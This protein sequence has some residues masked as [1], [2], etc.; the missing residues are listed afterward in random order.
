MKTVT[1]YIADDGTQFNNEQACV[2]YENSIKRNRKKINH[3][4]STLKEYCSSIVCSD[5]IAINR[6]DGTCAFRE[7]D[8]RDWEMEMK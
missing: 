5:C 8:P 6:F 1:T 3:A 4:I 2:V 7:N